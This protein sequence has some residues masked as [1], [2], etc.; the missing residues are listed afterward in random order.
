VGKGT[1][2]HW[3]FGGERRGIWGRS[4]LVREQLMPLL[5]VDRRVLGY[6]K[7]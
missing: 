2:C 7:V 5:R 4:A 1:G 3:E 6:V